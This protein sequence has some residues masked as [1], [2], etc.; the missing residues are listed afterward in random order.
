MKK[1]Y[2]IITYIFMIVLLILP[3]TRGVKYVPI[4]TID[5]NIQSFIEPNSLVKQDLTTF[6]SQYHIKENEYQEVLYYGPS[7]YIEAE[8]ITVIYAPN[9]PQ[10]YSKVLTHI[11]NQKKSFAGYGVE[12]TK[13]LEDATIKQIGDY[14]V[15]IV[16]KDDSTIYKTIKSL[17]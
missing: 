8:E 11:E 6:T 4:S 2:Q 14:V 16:A 5:E 3:F 1:I 12:Q 13:L 17:F 15:C 9:N 7:S 10:I